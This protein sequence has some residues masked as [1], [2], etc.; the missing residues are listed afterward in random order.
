[1][2]FPILIH[3]LNNKANHIVSSFEEL[4][5]NNYFKIIRTNFVLDNIEIECDYR[6]V[7]EAQKPEESLEIDGSAQEDSEPVGDNCA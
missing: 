1:M 7:D 6:W 5:I 4:P 2:K 3:L